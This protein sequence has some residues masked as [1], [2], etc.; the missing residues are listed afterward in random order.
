MASIETETA[1]PATCE[2]T[3]ITHKPQFFPY[4]RTIEAGDM[5]IAYM[6]SKQYGIYHIYIVLIYKQYFRIVII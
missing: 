5:V 2:A 3:M 4:K 1:I 6:V